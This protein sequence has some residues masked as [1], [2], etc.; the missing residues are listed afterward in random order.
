MDKQQLLNKTV[1]TLRP[2][3]TGNLM[4]S[5][6][7]VTLQDIFTHPAVLICITIVFLY[8]VIRRSKVVLLTLFAL[9]A[10]TVLMRYAIPAP[11]EA[12]SVKALLPFVSGGLLIG[13]VI[14][15]FTFIRSD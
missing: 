9:I 11:G 3:E 15:Y 1:E 7:N 14:I 8:G 4:N 5:I 10:A 2:L 6:Q 13:G 12:L